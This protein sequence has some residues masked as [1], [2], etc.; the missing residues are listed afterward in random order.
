MKEK[1]RSA[2]GYIVVET[3][4]CF[5]LF[6]FLV[7]SIISLIN[8]V[9]VQARVH[10]ALTQAAETVSM[11]SYVLE[12][13]GLAKHMESSAGM[14]EHVEQKA[15]EMKDH[16]NDVIDGIQGLMGLNITQSNVD[17]VKEGGSGAF[18][19][20]KGW[21]DE[22]V[23]NPK[24]SLQYLMNYALGQA[25]SEAFEA[26]LRPLVGHYLVNGPQDGDL[27]LRSFNVNDGAENYGIRGIVFSDFDLLTLDST[28][29]NDST[30]LTSVGDVKVVARYEVDYFFGILAPVIQPRLKI[31]QEVITH[32]WLNGKGEGYT[33]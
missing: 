26:M 5:L 18:D 16:I 17:L 23:N 13:T 8:I 6:V 15:D 2:R 14:R 31:T 32:A 20:G 12:V 22:A 25:P 4:A 21:V 11:Y 29:A 7:V 33:G 9:T 28:G 30:I 3:I 10:Y 24:K 27:Y 1:L 19:Q